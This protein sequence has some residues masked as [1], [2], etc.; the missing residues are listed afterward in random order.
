MAGGFDLSGYV[1]VAERLSQWYEKY[2]EGRITTQVIEHS[3]KRV[4][5]RAEA[6]RSQ[7]Q[8]TPSGVGHSGLSIPGAT[9]Y[10]RGAELENAETSAIGRALVAAGLPSK[11][12]A[13]ADEVLAKRGAAPEVQD[14]PAQE[15]IA[16]GTPKISPEDA[17]KFAMVFA[18]EEKGKSP[19]ACPKHSRPWTLREGV[20]AKGPYAFYSCGAKDPSTPKGWCIEKPSRVWEAAQEKKR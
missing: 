5:V 6:Y 2:P 7:D 12:V 3:E 14:G 20:S 17:L 4:I 19:E 15:V 11:K 16:E 13:S 1:E 10:T 8:V 9:P 18:E